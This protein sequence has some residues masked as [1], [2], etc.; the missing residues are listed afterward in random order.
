MRP[1]VSGCTVDVG[2][3]NEGKSKD[4]GG[5]MRIRSRQR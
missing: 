5:L 2:E 1:G 3:T 4:D